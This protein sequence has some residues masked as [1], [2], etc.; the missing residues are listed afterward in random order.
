M[1][2]NAQFNFCFPYDLFKTSKNF[3]STERSILACKPFLRHPRQ[4]FPP[5]GRMLHQ[6]W[7][8]IRTR[9]SKIMWRP[10]PGC[11][12]ARFRTARSFRSA[13]RFSGGVR[14]VSPSLGPSTL[15]SNF[16][17][18]SFPSPLGFQWAPCGAALS[19]CGCRRKRC[20]VQNPA[21]F[22]SGW[23]KLQQGFDSSR[24]PL[25]FIYFVLI[26]SGLRRYFFDRT[27]LY[28]GE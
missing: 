13:C 2:Y 27:K 8:R 12:A 22:P 5:F 17:A 11:L 1:T 14:N 16:S 24:A 15:F 26:P 10:F 20:G 4:L 23:R 7:V 19:V 21:A 6:V 18:F 28:S 3:S 25:H 9:L